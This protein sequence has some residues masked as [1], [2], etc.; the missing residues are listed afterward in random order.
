MHLVLYHVSKLNSIKYI[1]TIPYSDL[2]HGE[3]EYVFG[4]FSVHVKLTSSLGT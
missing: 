3:I 4:T 2:F 1:S